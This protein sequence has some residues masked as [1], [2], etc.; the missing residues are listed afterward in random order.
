MQEIV[1]AEDGISSLVL[2]YVLVG[3]GAWFEDFDVF[4]LNSFNVY[5]VP[6]LFL[7]AVASGRGGFGRSCQ[8]MRQS[9]CLGEGVGS[10]GGAIEFW[11]E[12][13]N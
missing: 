8:R 7:L 6:S 4:V 11:S 9:P 10:S 3:V 5:L 13:G 2:V 12:R 1:R